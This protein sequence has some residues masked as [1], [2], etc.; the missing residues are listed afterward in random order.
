MRGSRRE[1]GA[2]GREDVDEPWPFV[3]ERDGRRSTVYLEAGQMLLYEGATCLH[4]RP[5]PL[6]GRSFANLFVHYRPTDWPWNRDEVA[7]AGMNQGLIDVF[8]RPTAQFR[9]A[10]DA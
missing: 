6:Q 8:G 5:S 3:L 1:F 10:P 4:A 2:A 7:R 9:G